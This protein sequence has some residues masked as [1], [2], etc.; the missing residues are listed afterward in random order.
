MPP[1]LD[2]G[3]WLET[4]KAVFYFFCKNTED[5]RNTTVCILRSLLHQTLKQYP[6]TR[7]AVKRAYNA[8]SS[9]LDELHTLSGLFHKAMASPS[10]KRVWLVID[11]LDECKQESW[12]PLV[13]KLL[14]APFTTDTSTPSP[15]MKVKLLILT[16]PNAIPLR[17][18]EGSNNLVKYITRPNIANDL[19]RFIHNEVPRLFKDPEIR[20][21]VSRDLS[22]RSGGTFLWVAFALSYVESLRLTEPFA[23]DEL[24]SMPTKLRDIYERILKDAKSHSL[25]QYVRPTLH[26]ILAAQRPPTTNE[27]AL[28]LCFV[29]SSPSKTPDNKTIE[30]MQGASQA[31]DLLIQKNIR[32]TVSTIS[33]IHQSLKDLLEE[34]KKRLPRALRSYVFDESKSRI[35]LETACRAYLS[36]DEVRKALD[37][38]EHKL[39]RTKSR[40]AGSSIGKDGATLSEQQLGLLT[41][42]LRTTRWSPPRGTSHGLVLWQ[43]RRPDELYH[44]WN[45]DY[46]ARV[47][48]F[49]ENAIENAHVSALQFFCRILDAMNTEENSWRRRLVSWCLLALEHGHDLLLEPLLNELSLL[50]DKDYLEN[51]VQIGLYNILKFLANKS[52]AHQVERRNSMSTCIR[53][54]QSHLDQTD[55]IRGNA[56]HIAVRTYIAEAVQICIEQHVDVFAKDGYGQT[57]LH[58]AVRKSSSEVVELLLEEHSIK[59]PAEDQKGRGRGG[60]TLLHYAARRNDSAVLEALLKCHFGK[61]LIYTANNDGELPIHTAIHRRTTLGN[62]RLLLEADVEKTSLCTTNLKGQTALDYA[63]SRLEQCSG[64]IM[65][66]DRS[67]HELSSSADKWEQIVAYLEKQGTLAVAVLQ[68]EIPG[69]S[70][71][72]SEVQQ[73]MS[74]PEDVTAKSVSAKD[75][76]FEEPTIQGQPLEQRLPHDQIKEPVHVQYP[77]SHFQEL[78]NNIDKVIGTLL[79]LHPQEATQIR[80]EVFQLCEELLSSLTIS[81]PSQSVSA[82]AQSQSY[83]KENQA[84]N[85]QDDE[86]L[87]VDHA[88]ASVVGEGKDSSNAEEGIGDDGRAPSHSSEL[89]NLQGTQ[90]LA[91]E[92]PPKPLSSS[93]KHL[94]AVLRSSQLAHLPRDIL[95]PSELLLKL[96]YELPREYRLWTPLLTRLFY[97]IGSPESFLQLRDACRFIRRTPF[98]ARPVSTGNSDLA[99]TVQ[100]LDSLEDTDCVASVLRRYHLSRL[101]EYRNARWQHHQSRFPNV[102]VTKFKHGHVRVKQ[103]KPNEGQK[104]AA[105]A[106]LKDLLA[107]AYPQLHDES[108]KPL[109]KTSGPHQR[110][111]KSLKRRLGNGRNWLALSQ[112]FSA[113]ILSLVPTG[114]DF[115]IHNHQI[116]MIPAA[117]FQTFLS[118]LSSQRGGFLRMASAMLSKGIFEVLM[119]K[120]LD[121]LWYPLENFNEE[122]CES[123]GF[124]SFAL[125]T[126]CTSKAGENPRKTNPQFLGGEGVV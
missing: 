125:V 67:G 82:A 59:A 81:M 116:E 53:L 39:S 15:G 55:M 76:V 104:T 98:K 78:K 101:L 30:Q 88:G 25:R 110:A 69:G 45:S 29:E 35:E 65:V 64:G 21:D 91:A 95:Q 99:E 52:E 13:Q 68:T 120:G 8:S 72:A 107:E 112:A 40:L 94:G 23:R 50:Q 97:A 14:S 46:E 2:S 119:G 66:Q 75:T 19:E 54:C 51:L 93:D 18:V 56:L 10:L 34:K 33:I 28:L 122:T 36:T 121:Q 41:F 124:D 96:Q 57:P 37:F 1:I 26:L 16:R 105:S 43:L 115:S 17:T 31:C 11:G 126:G 3:F 106:A 114:G 61:E 74:I 70:C 80:H 108:G 73:T 7:E 123:E 48:G 49:A 92:P 4:G 62:V 5:T 38:V 102:R 109:S 87:D 47:C 24:R 113:G 103:A 71:S 84:S 90:S 12:E 117:A 63:R 77:G 60:N 42:A 20:D 89:D 86:L 9:A 83:P 100:A 111:Y 6:D 79:E 44:G 85:I 118:V 22:T 27:L 32:G 58:Y